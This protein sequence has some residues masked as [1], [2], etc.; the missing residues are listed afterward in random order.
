M[1]RRSIAGVLALAALSFT[2]CSKS[3]PSPS[4]APGSGK[5]GGRILHHVIHQPDA[6]YG[7]DDVIIWQEPER[8]NRAFKLAPGTK[9]D[10]IETVEGD[11]HG[12]EGVI[13]KIKTGEGREGWVPKKWCKPV[14]K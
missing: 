11:P 9:V 14:K 5:S 4:T 10:V 2:A 12:V 3:K 7:D 6:N 8:K 13:F 1:P